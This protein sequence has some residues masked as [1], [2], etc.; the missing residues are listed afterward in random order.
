MDGHW[1][2][3]LCPPIL[4]KEA[5]D[6]NAHYILKD[7]QH[8]HKVLN[9]YDIYNNITIFSS[10]FT[11]FS[12]QKL[13][14]WL[15]VTEIMWALLRIYMYASIKEHFMYKKA[16]MVKN[17]HKWPCDLNLW[18][19]IPT[20]IIGSAKRNVCTKFGWN[21]LTSSL[22]EEKVFLI[23]YDLVFGQIYPSPLRTC[24]LYQGTYTWWSVPKMRSMRVSGIWEVVVTR[25]GVTA[26]VAASFHI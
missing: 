24:A 10:K 16:Q 9:V 21:P 17:M 4:F 13:M 18:T 5:G 26:V 6:N 1:P 23:T 25:R 11:K 14:L 22:P 3:I 7:T 8:W 12:Y 15:V 19:L 2:L 20:E